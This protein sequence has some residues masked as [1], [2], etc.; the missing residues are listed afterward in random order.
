M[1]KVNLLAILA[2][3]FGLTA[4][5]SC[6]TDLT[7][8]TDAA[9]TATATDEN[10]AASINDQVVSTSDDYLNALDAT[11]YQA[12]KSNTGSTPEKTSIKLTID[13]ITITV[14]RV[15][16]N[17]YPKNIC[18]DF[19]TGVTVKR[20]NVLK[21]KIYIT[22]SNKMTIANSTRTFLFSDFYVNNNA[23][24][25]SKVVTYMG[26]NASSQPYWTI[27][28]NDTIIRADGSKVTW[29]SE[30]VRTR[31]DNNNTPNIYWDDTYSITGSSNGVNAK[32]VAYTMTIM[33]TNPLIISG[34]FPYFTKGSVT[35]TTDSKTVLVDYGDGTKD[36]IATATINGVT[37][38][39]NLKK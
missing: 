14:D 27:T 30:R 5:V 37:K 36:T 1:K 32:G 35:I 31:I 20:G 25:G 16:L 18:L 28:A 26:L 29:N 23:V 22:V 39:F 3:S 13:S 24:K 9:L 10:Q 38:E 19:G 7:S 34:N 11:G 21:G 8:A 12:V 33:D 2:I 15:G 4:M 6:T 17:D